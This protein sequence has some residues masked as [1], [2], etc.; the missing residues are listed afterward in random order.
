[1]TFISSSAYYLPETKGSVLSWCD[2][3]KRPA[4]HQRALLDSGAE[5]FF[6]ANGEHKTLMAYQAVS[7]LLRNAALKADE[8]DVLIF[9]HTSQVAVLA[10]PESLAERVRSK[11]GMH[12]TLTF[13]ISQ[14]NCVSTLY[15]LKVLDALFNTHP[16][17]RYAIAFGVDTIAIETLRAIGD[18]GI[19][20]DAASALLITPDKG[21]AKIKA[22]E[23]YNDPRLVHG[24]LS[25]GSYE[26]NDNY[27]WSAISVIRRSLKKA[28]IGADDLT[29]IV[30]H[31]TNYPGWAH[32][33][34]AL[35]IPMEKLF[36]ANF[37]RIG[38][39]FGSDCAINIC[40]G[41]ILQRPGYHLVF[42]S[43][44]GGCFGSMILDCGGTDGIQH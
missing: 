22:I 38:H 27:L 30:P 17:W 9:F 29:S 4:E 11:L 1:M 33:L 41:G 2:N 6:F 25:D 5:H 34:R 37:A 15:A 26:Q 18:S 36:S 7:Q 23:T 32:V 21:P 16:E 28:G 35:K 39:A 8:I 14:Q 40:D 19:H 31:N 43:G 10:P 44:I 20:S 24:I 42:S 3:H 12:K 13:S